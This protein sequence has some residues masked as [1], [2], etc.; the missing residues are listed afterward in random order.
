MKLVCDC[1]NEMEFIIDE[2]VEHDDEKGEFVRKDYS[3]FDFWAEHDEA[4][5][6]CRK[7]KKA[8]WYFT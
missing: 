7:C 3:K 6:E 1:G 5:F 4:G 2:E 8:I